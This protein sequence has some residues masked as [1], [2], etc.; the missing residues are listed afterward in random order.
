M[1]KIYKV[2]SWKRPKR[3]SLFILTTSLGHTKKETCLFVFISHINIDKI[4][5][6]WYF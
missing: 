3:V 5:F 2:F 4:Q 6:Q 1:K